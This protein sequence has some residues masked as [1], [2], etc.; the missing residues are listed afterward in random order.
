MRSDVFWG[1]WDNS[2]QDT[3]YGATGAKRLG[4]TFNM[5]AVFTVDLIS[6][7]PQLAVKCDLMK[8][9]P[10]FKWMLPSESY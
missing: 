1:N 3:L 2:F 10:L 7:P 9:Y 6:N 8:I 4:L 5:A